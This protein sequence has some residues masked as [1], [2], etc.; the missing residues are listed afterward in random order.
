MCC[1]VVLLAMEM[2]CT[3]VLVSIYDVLLLLHVNI[4]SF[5]YSDKSWLSTNFDHYLLRHIVGTGTLAPRRDA[6][7]VRK[8][9]SSS[10][11]ALLVSS[12][13]SI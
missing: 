5:L 8:D 13:I 6:D 10:R 7:L 12:S 2:C 4:S 1:V 9:V 11:E 3:T